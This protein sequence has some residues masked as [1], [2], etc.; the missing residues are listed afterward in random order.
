VILVVFLSGVALCRRNYPDHLQ[1]LYVLVA[2]LAL[3]QVGM[4]AVL[5]QGLRYFYWF[6]PICWLFVLMNAST[7][8]S[9]I[10]PKQRRLALALGGATISLAFLGNAFALIAGVR[11]VDAEMHGFSP[12]QLRAVREIQMPAL[13]RLVPVEAPIVSDRSFVLWYLG[14]PTIPL[15]LD[16]GSLVA[17]E[18]DYFAIDYIY[19]TGPFFRDMPGDPEDY[20][21]AYFVDGGGAV[22]KGR[23]ARLALFMRHFPTYAIAQEFED[24][25][26]VLARN[27]R[28]PAPPGC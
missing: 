13:R 9:S 28:K 19:L 26:V 20:I 25:A 10:L 6:I 15:P 24:G 4:F 1:R 16:A 7:L 17:I 27:R 14:N 22:A 21:R 3:W 5:R 11:R 2:C 18:R 12:A 23:S 8:L